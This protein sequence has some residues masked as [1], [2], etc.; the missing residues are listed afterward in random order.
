LK[1]QSKRWL[2][3]F[4]TFFHPDYDRRL[5]F[6]TISTGAE[7]TGTTATHRQTHLND[8]VLLQTMTRVAGL[9]MERDATR[10]IAIVQ[11]LSYFYRRWGFSPRPEG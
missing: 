2:R 8:S 10:S 4:V 9:S 6:L 1:R 3:W 11:P 5:W 7:V